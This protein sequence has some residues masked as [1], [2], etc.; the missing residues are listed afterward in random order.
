M[1][2][3]IISQ[4]TT[5]VNPDDASSATSITSYVAS[6]TF[7][8]LQKNEKL[9]IIFDANYD[10]SFGG[11]ESLHPFDTKKYG[12]VSQYLLKAFSLTPD[13]FYKPDL[14][15]DE[16]LLLVHTQEYLETL[17]NSFTLGLIADMPFLGLLPNKLAQKALLHPVKLATGGTIIGADLALEY[18]WAINLSGG[19]H[20]A[21]KAEPVAGGFCIIN[22]ICIAARKILLKHPEYRI[23]IVDLDAHQGNGHEDVAENEK[24]IAIFDIYNGKTWPGDFPCQERI[25][26]N[27]PV[28]GRKTNDAV[29]LALLNE[30]LPKA[31]DAVKPD[32]I[33]Y[34]AGTD[35]YYEDPIGSMALTI[36]GIINRDELVFTQAITRNI[37]ILMVLSG[38][39]H[40]KSY[41]II[42]KSVE[43]VWYKL[44]INTLA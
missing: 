3:T 4:L 14:V 28:D 16:D 9:P 44:L 22:D 39:Y 11:L 26:Y 7:K 18:G 1:L 25:N 40:S 2:K 31:I 29:Y 32:L 17:K 27:F 15:T 35:V 13:Q 38:G 10:I 41:Q 20:H 8:K 12:K 5:P 21:K 34:N 6:K 37:P 19:Y 23:L 33:I 30:E 24:Q 36:P 42:S 43:N